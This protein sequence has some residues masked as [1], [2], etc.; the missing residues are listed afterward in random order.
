MVNVSEKTKQRYVGLWNKIQVSDVSLSE[1]DTISYSEF[2]ERTN[3]NSESQFRLAKSL[4]RNIERQVQVN[5][6]LDKRDIPKTII[7]RTPEKQ[8]IPKV[9]K[10]RSKQKILELKEKALDRKERRERAKEREQVKIKA[11]KKAE[12]LAKNLK[13]TF[14]K[15]V[16]DLQITEGIS[17]R[18][19][20][21]EVSG[22]LK[23]PKRD[24]RHLSR[25]RRDILA[26]YGY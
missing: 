21:K 1:L 6:Y 5:S 17:E 16:K 11:E 4:A 8:V 10:R 2:Q 22:L 25:N 19:A 9:K 12:R 3:I 15:M 18:L 20:I 7:K 26:E 14:M 13:G 23:L 24:Y